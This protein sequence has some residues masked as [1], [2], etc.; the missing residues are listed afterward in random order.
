MSSVNPTLEGLCLVPMSIAQMAGT[1]IVICM[2]RGSNLR[3]PTYSLEK[4]EFYP[5]DY[6]KKKKV[7]VSL[8]RG[9]AGCWCVKATFIIRLQ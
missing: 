7:Y 5:L 1:C 9:S 4:G 2:G 3:H 8:Y 6:L